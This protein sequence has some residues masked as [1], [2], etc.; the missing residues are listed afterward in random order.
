MKFFARVG[1]LSL[2]WLAVLL[3]G[4]GFLTSTARADILNFDVNLDPFQ[5]APPHNTPGYGS[6]D[7]TLDTV[8]GYVAVTNNSGIYADLLAGAITVRIQDAPIGSN[9]ATI[10]SLT[11]DTPGNTSA[12]FSGGGTITAGQVT[13]MINTNT[14]VN[15]TDSVF[16]S[17]EIRGQIILVPEPTSAALVALGSLGGFLVLRRR[18]NQ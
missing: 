7:L 3:L 17:G 8:S 10:V 14:Y 5:E 13:D 6:A 11:L 12:T 15:I 18:R 4:A 16:P 2:K 1:F 9:G